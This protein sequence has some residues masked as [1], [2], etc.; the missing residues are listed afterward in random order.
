VTSARDPDDLAHELAGIIGDGHLLRDEASCALAGSDLFRWPGAALPDM[1]LGPADTAE[2]AACLAALP[3]AGRPVVPRGAGLS[4]TAGVVPQRPAAVLDLRRLD[5]VRVEAGDLTAI[6][7]A[8]CTWQR[9]AEALAPHGLRPV[10]AA[11]ISGSHSTVGGAASQGLPGGLDG[12]VGLTVALADGTV[13][14][15]GSGAISGGLPFW[16]YHGPDLTGLFLGDCGAFG[17][18]T[19]IVL[20]LAPERACAHASFAFGTGGDMLAALLLLQRGG[21]VSRA[22]AMDRT[23]IEAAGRPGLGEV[24]RVAAGVAM[25]AGSP[26][27]AL[28]DLAVLRHVGDA[29]EAAWSLHLTVEGV[30]ETTAEAQLRHARSVCRT[31]GREISP[32][33]PKA[34]RARPFSVRGMVGSGGER[35]VPVHGILAMSRAEACLAALQTHLA[36]RAPDL[37]GA[38]IRLSWLI[39]S[40]G[41]YVSIEPMFLWRDALDPIHL[42]HLSTRNRDRFGGAAEDLP[43]RALVRALRTELRDI[44]DRHGATHAQLGRFYRGGDALEPGARALLEGVKRALDPAGRM[45]PGVLGLGS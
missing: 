45:N 5:A 22:F 20:R 24:L 42:A 10:L 7:G 35:W 40:A 38:G 33:I 19:E 23:R 29:T 43:A 15:T 36:G 31:R 6:V 16:R 27:R 26:L 3:R 11:P 17:V 34:M 32:T 39:S 21:L 9:L 28:R 1:V 13:V 2:T 8:G 14:R 37:S 25:R 41:A 4:Y 18:K 44:F 12:V 30:D